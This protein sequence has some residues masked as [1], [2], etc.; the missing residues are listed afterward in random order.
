M[1]K[2]KRATH[3]PPPTPP[4]HSR[5]TTSQL[6]AAC[7]P[8][9]SRGPGP[10]LK[11]VRDK[12]LAGVLRHG[13]RLA[14]DAAS[15]AAAAHAWLAPAAP[16]G[17]EPEPGTLERTWRVSQDELVSSLAERGAARGAFDWALPDL[18]PYSVDW[19]PSGRFLL[20]GG[21]RGHLALT[22]VISG[23]RHAELFVPDAVE[24][25]IQLHSEAFFAAAHGGGVYIYDKRGVELHAAREHAGATRLAFLRN[26]FL[27][28]SAGKGGVIRWQ[29]VTT[30]ELVAQ[31]ASRL[32]DTRCLTL[33]PHNAVLVAGHAGGTI[34]M[35][36]P[37]SNV[38]VVRMLTHGGPVVAAAVDA[39]GRHLLTAGAD[40]QVKV[41]DVRSLK[42]MHA[43]YSR[44][45]VT[46]LAISQRGLV[47]VASPRGAVIWR[48][49]LATKA[50]SPYMR[51]D[52]P[53]QPPGTAGVRDI[54]FRPFEDVLAL[55]HGGGV[56]CALVPGAGEPN[57][58][59]FVADPFAA[60]RA[61]QEGEVR[62][63]LDKLAAD[64][65]VLD[66]SSVGA[67]LKE[68]KAVR[69]ERAAAALAANAA[70]AAAARAAG[71]KRSRMKGK[72][73]PTR[74]QKKKQFV[75]I[76]ERKAA[77]RSKL[78]GGARGKEADDEVPADVPRA[79]QRLYKKH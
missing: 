77:L 25:A 26:H 7:V 56:R 67:V 18:G 38:P 73:K 2:C 15:S 76:E 23:T 47:G 30:G 70:A 11:S 79:L 64:S 1:R 75:I 54:A 46:G 21:K 62:A 39:G 68:P 66:P 51:V 22:D 48:G 16:G 14:R 43:Y 20:L 31:H 72:N 32:G 10:A 9:F 5:K 65:I 29:D 12:K 61:R 78:A 63:L 55:G 60:R 35:W 36:T 19:S 34:T 69:D 45:P 37:N 3:A 27:L 53:P 71:D 40:H 6:A 49:A 13:E 42:P 8:V 59:S 41:W 58:D 50:D 28:A 24:D 17:L 4:T 74:R 44:S 52:L 33:N 57:L